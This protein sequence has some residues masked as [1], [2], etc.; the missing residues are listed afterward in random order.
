MGDA[1]TARKRCPTGDEGR[2]KAVPMELK[3]EDEMIWDDLRIEK[4]QERKT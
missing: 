1:V 2:N 3:L 4:I